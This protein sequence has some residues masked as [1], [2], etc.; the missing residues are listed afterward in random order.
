MEMETP[1]EAAEGSEEKGLN[2]IFD[3]FALLKDGLLCMELGFH[4]FLC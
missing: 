2:L 1:E 4:D 3:Y